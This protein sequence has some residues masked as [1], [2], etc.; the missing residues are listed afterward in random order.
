MTVP[1]GVTSLPPGALTADN[2]ASQLEDM[3]PDAMHAR[4][5]ARVPATYNDS[6]GGD[7][8]VDMTPMGVITRLFAGFISHVANAD[9]ADIQSPNDLPGLLNDF[10]HELPVVG[11]FVR[12]LDALAGTYVGDDPVLL[13]IQ[14][15]FG[16]VRGGLNNVR[17]FL[18]SLIGEGADLLHMTPGQAWQQIMTTWLS[19]MWW[20]NKIPIGAISS[21]VP[22]LLADFITADSL[23]G[24]TMWVFDPDVEPAGEVGS[25]RTTLDGTVHELISER[26]QLDIGRKVSAAVKI[27]YSG[28]TAATGSPIRLSWIGWNGDTEVDGGDF[29]V[30][31]PSGAALDWTALSGSITRQASDPWDRVSVVLKTTTGGTAGTV[32]FGAAEGTKPDKLPKNL[33]DGLEDALAAAGQ[34]I[35]DAICNALGI[36][37]SGHT[38]LDV[39][40]ALT[41]IPKQAV[42]GLED[43]GDDVRNG[44]KA[45][46]NGLFN[47]TD[48]TGSVAQV[49]Q[50]AEA[51]RIALQG[52]LT[53][54]TFPTSNS[55]WVI[56]AGVTE[57]YGVT[58]DAGSNGFRGD[59]GGPG[60]GYM[61]RRIDLTGLTPGTSTLNI[62]VGAA[63]GTEGGTGGATTI[64]D[65]S[66]NLLVGALG[67]VG[68]VVSDMDLLATTSSAGHGGAGGTALGASPYTATPG[69]AGT[70]SGL[71]AGGAGGTRI[72][73][74]GG[75]GSAKAGDG[76]DGAA[77]QTGDV[78]ICGGGGGGGGGGCTS[79]SV[80]MSPHGGDGGDGGYPGGGGGGG[81]QAAGGS[82]PGSGAF[83][84]GANG[85][86]A[87]LYKLGGV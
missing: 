30:H 50:V 3:T 63:S 53:L 56:P 41:N 57:L 66:G 2:M 8:A 48:G 14:D 19:P 29:A 34:T 54:Q 77:G 61:R 11:E 16:G 9:P 26:I 4:A 78:P 51:V 22:N 28:V 27:K 12:L 83:G 74:I 5:A 67:G 71:A 84:F 40:H 36:S 81:G 44:F 32:W 21:E 1:G 47:R 18:E 75:V 72:Q 13:Q 68:G 85:F 86:A 38:D 70:A 73:G 82:S 76:G 49:Q 6:T 69:D 10:I 59:A 42:E 31:Q 58:L 35:R 23:V 39:I 64:K 65:S 37:G 46:W 60:G 17:E 20:L 15:L 43:L 79:T 45:F 7:P 52:G 33:V 25:A 55:A 24:E 80:G 87:A 62:A